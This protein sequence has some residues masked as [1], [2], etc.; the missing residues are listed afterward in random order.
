MATQTTSNTTLRPSHRH[1]HHGRLAL[2][3]RLVVL[4]VFLLV[5]V[6]PST[7]A[8]ADQNACALYTGDAQRICAAAVAARCFADAHSPACD[9]LAQ[10]WNEECSDC[11][12]P[13]PWGP[14]CPC[15]LTDTTGVEFNAE[16]L[17]AEVLSILWPY[18]IESQTCKDTRKERSVVTGGYNYDYDVGTGYF[19][20]MWVRASTDANSVKS[21]DY[22]LNNGNPN[23]V[24]PPKHVSGL[25]TGELGACR[26]DIKT[27]IEQ[28]DTSPY[29]CGF[30]LF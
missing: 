2:V 7:P 4:S 10:T 30:H 23:P 3:G 17:F 24:L 22:F 18:V 29:F 20:W 11:E 1:V 25:T 28:L 21:C 12:G 9:A 26:K 16:D 13:A 15:N 6:V 8:H 27:L 14:T 19:A 5:F